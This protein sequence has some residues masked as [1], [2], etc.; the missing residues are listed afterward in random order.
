MLSDNTIKIIKDK[1]TIDHLATLLPECFDTD[2][3]IGHTRWATHGAPNKT[4]SH[5]HI[6]KSKKFPLSITE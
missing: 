6:S 3:A 1:G 5:P 4:N 2:L